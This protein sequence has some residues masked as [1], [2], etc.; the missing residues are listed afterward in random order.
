MKKT[1]VALPLVAG[2][3][4]AAYAGTSHLAGSQTQTEYQALLA[5]LNK[6]LPLV[7]VN[8]SYDA[9]I[10]SSEAITRVMTSQSADADVLF[11]LHHDISHSP[12]QMSDTGVKV[13]EVS[14][15]TTLHDTES[16]PQE[17]IKAFD[18]EHPFKM[19]T[20][21]KITGQIDNE[22]T[23]SSFNV[24]SDEVSINWSGLTLDTLTDADVTK[25]SGS[26]GSISFKEVATGGVMSVKESPFSFDL[27]HHGDSI[28]TG[29]TD[30]SFNEVELQN[31]SMPA[32]ISFGRFSVKTDT[33]MSEGELDIGTQ[34]AVSDISS[35]LPI[36]QATM[37][38]DL[39]KLLADGFRQ[40]NGLMR[41]LA[42]NPETASEAFSSQ[43]GEAVLAMFD[44]GSSLGVELA[45]SNDEGDVNANLRLGVKETGQEG[46]TAD[47]LDKIVTGRDILN[48][49][50]FDGAM[51]A[52]I[53]ALA[54][55]PVMMM[56]G[57]A[58]DYIT[59]G[60]DAITS[61]VLLEGSTLMV[62]GVEIPLDL[63]LG[64]MLDMP[65][66]DLM[67]M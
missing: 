37:N 43:I 22:I 19:L 24:D 11:R 28:Y 40:Y 61:E 18:D 42:K 52:E 55:T 59:V 56:L 44:N 49:L 54:Q 9:G 41:D 67:R 6:Q 34:L 66:A 53:A 7:F 60:E 62:N 65:L 12:V 47:A 2:F 20:G 1:L 16:M 31:P 3:A 51:Y 26:A 36:K 15:L 58:G 46:M 63:M 29:T 38:F 14:I 33:K 4:A 48:V 39:K 45:L 35:M 8:E 10:S 21:V 25:G 50:S 32:P 5:Q 17:L 27:E 57:F 13:G 30:L 23:V 64:D